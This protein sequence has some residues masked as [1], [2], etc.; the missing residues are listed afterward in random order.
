MKS[1]SSAFWKIINVVGRISGVLMVVSGTI[2]AIVSF[3]Q[4]DT[5]LVIFTG[6]VAICG[7]LLLLAKPSKPN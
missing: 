7:V 4:R 2:M 6:A 1:F 5:A 3:S